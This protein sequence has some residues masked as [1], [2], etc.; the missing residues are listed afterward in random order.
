[1]EDGVGGE[2]GKGGGKGSTL[3]NDCKWLEH[4]LQLAETISRSSALRELRGAARVRWPP[5]R[6]RT[7]QPQSWLQSLLRS[8][9]PRLIRIVSYYYFE[10]HHT[11]RETKC[12]V[13]HK[14]GRAPQLTTQVVQ[15]ERYQCTW[16]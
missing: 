9:L 11:A 8:W 2:R 15:R 5:A 6:A 3:G 10:K 12:S 13:V 14:A 1:M 7:F 4:A 16:Q